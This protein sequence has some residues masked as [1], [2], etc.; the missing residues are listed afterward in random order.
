MPDWFEI[1]DLVAREGWF[2][3][4]LTSVDQARTWLACGRVG[5]PRVAAHTAVLNSELDEVNRILLEREED[6]AEAIAEGVPL[7]FAG[8]HL[9][10]D[11][12]YVPDDDS[13]YE[14]ADPWW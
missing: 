2:E 6:E 5:A 4:F 3:D 8:Y 7:F 14:W 13:D 11:D 1:L 10:S 9:D 12:H